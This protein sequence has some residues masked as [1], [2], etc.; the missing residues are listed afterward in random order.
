MKTLLGTGMKGAAFG[1]YK[2]KKSIVYF[3]LK[4]E[5]QYMETITN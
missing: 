3:F 1:G 4:Y 5:K 2:A